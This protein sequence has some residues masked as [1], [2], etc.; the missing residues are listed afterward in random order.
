MKKL[1]IA[2]AVLALAASSMSA[3]PANAAV[4][5]AAKAVVLSE[6]KTVGA[7]A[8]GK[9]ADGSNLI[10]QTAKFGGMKGKKVWQYK[11]LP[12]ISNLDIMIPT[13]SLTSGYGGFG[14]AIADA[15]KSEGL[16]RREAVITLKPAPYNLGL[17]YLNKDLAGKAGKLAVTGFAQ[18]GGAFQSKS[19]YL[20]SDATPVARMYAEYNAIAV[21]ADSKYT[22]IQELVA[23]L[24]KDPKSMTVVGGTVGGV[25]TYTAAQLF[26]ALSID[27]SNLTYVANN[28]KVAA[29]LLSDAKYAYGISSYGDFAPYVKAGTLKILAV[30]SPVA[31]RG[32]SAPTLKASG[33]NLV[34]ENWRGIL[35]PP[36][37]SAAGKATVIRA[38]DIVNNSKSYKAYLTSQSGFT[39]W[40]P[41][42]KFESW[43]KTEESKIRRIYAN[44]GLL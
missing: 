2:A 43:L 17:T 23:D 5:S 28:G 18:V 36:N 1:I 42:V 6:C 12:V 16:S 24:K 40:L 34:I 20:A 14:K 31:M 10:C 11:A 39:N 32:V 4:V 3:V 27:I 22:T 9:G 29:S 8:K 7:V 21:K 13:N 19:G 15:L 25:D 30:T 35:L 26:D 33:I 37:T 38:L 44:I 41:G